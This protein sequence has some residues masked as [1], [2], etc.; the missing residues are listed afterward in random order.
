MSDREYCQTLHNSAMAD[1]GFVPLLVRLEHLIEHNVSFEHLIQTKRLF[2]ARI[3]LI[4]QAS[5]PGARPD[6]RASH[7][8]RQSHGRAFDRCFRRGSG[9]KPAGR[10]CARRRAELYR[11][12]CVGKYFR[13]QCLLH[14]QP[15]SRRRAEF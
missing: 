9:S 6:A 12:L 5:V 10:N 2:A 1:D 4:A 13:D 7:E 15:H 11:Q 8:P 3:K 14:H